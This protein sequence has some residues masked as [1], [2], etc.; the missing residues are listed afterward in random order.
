[1]SVLFY[2]C[3]FWLLCNSCLAKPKQVSVT[4]IK[5]KGY[6][7]EELNYPDVSEVAYFTAEIT[8]EL[9]NQTTLVL[10]NSHLSRLPL[11]VFRTLDKLEH[12]DVQGCQVQH[13]AAECFE[14]AT[15][16][17]TLQLAG[18]LISKLNS[19][20]FALAT[21]LEELNLADNRL[22]NLPA[23]AFAGLH[24]L[25]QLWL[26]DNQLQQLPA[27]IF[28]DLQQVQQLNLDNN[29]LTELPEELCAEQAQLQQFSARGNR[30]KRIAA[31]AF[32]SVQRLI[33]SDNP[34]LHRLH[35]AGHI[36]ELQADNCPLESLQLDQADQLE[37]LLL[38][39]TRL[40]SLE[41]LRNASSL[42]DLDLT[43]L[44]QLPAIP[45][46][47]PAQQLKRL[48]ISYAN[49][50]NWPDQILKQL[51]EL[52]VLDVWHNQQREIYIKD[53]FGPLNSHYIDNTDS[54]CGQLE[55]FVGDATLAKHITIFDNEVDNQAAYS[56]QCPGVEVAQAEELIW[57]EDDA[58]S[59]T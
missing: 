22:D 24:K 8:K 26:Q 30:L 27:G 25:R 11:N 21:E 56:M 58:D 9:D 47:W 1:M 3:L 32:P 14:S 19:A 5:C 59:L 37:Q 23:R 46:P 34:Q 42:L 4:S 29:Q 28:T 2:L 45:D 52:K 51:P 50:S 49:D 31:N 7:C 16:L 10:R 43:G 40:Q 57:F 38:S 35:L 20:N 39:N 48:S 18:N 15:K 36:R 44:D 17:K 6:L 13:V 41:F 33:I 53:D 54:L 12:L 55:Q